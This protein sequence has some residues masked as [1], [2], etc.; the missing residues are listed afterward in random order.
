[1]AEMEISDGRFGELRWFWRIY[2]CPELL[3]ADTT[4]AVLVREPEHVLYLPLLYRYWKV[5]HDVLE[6]LLIQESLP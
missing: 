4:V 5:P 6:V 3:I 2:H 1:M